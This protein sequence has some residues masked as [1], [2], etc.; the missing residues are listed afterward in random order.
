MLLSG[1]SSSLES[2]ID[3]ILRVVDAYSLSTDMAVKL[4]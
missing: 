1:E 3:E 4:P 2:S